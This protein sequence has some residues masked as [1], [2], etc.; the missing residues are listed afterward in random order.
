MGQQQLLLLIISVV[1]VLLA[2]AIGMLAF[3]RNAAQSN[4]DAL[5]SDAVDIATDA[6]AWMMKSWIYGG[7]GNSC[8]E[9]CDWSAIELKS[10]GYRTNDEGAYENLNGRFYLDGRSRPRNLYIIAENVSYGNRVTLTLRGVG[11]DQ[12][13]VRLQQVGVE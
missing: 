13:S 10:L 5:V 2:V 8:L 1:L 11:P 6:Q 9:A 7:G 4:K 12:I 3:S